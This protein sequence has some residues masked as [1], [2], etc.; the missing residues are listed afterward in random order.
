MHPIPATVPI[1]AWLASFAFDT[2]SWV[3][4][5]AHVLAVGSLWLMGIGVVGGI[6]A[7]A[8]GF[9]GLPQVPAGGHV[10]S[11][12]LPGFVEAGRG[13]PAWAM[14]ACA[15]H[16]AISLSLQRSAGERIGRGAA[17]VAVDGRA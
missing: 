1:G 6:G 17:L 5:P 8:T 14:T 4:G 11:L 12:P 13:I 9:L 16:V 3:G 15:A 7:A 10:G 2:G